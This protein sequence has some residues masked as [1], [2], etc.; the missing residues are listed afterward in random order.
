MLKREF[1]KAKNTVTEKLSNEF[2]YR[3]KV[4]DSLK[5][6]NLALPL[7]DLLNEREMSHQEA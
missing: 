7:V 6:I 1:N 3:F 2:C 4:N 5:A